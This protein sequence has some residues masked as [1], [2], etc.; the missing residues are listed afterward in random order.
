MNR[1]D[2]HFRAVNHGTNLPG[3]RIRIA[4]REEKCEIEGEKA[5]AF[6]FPWPGFVRTVWREDLVAEQHE[7]RGRTAEK[8]RSFIFKT[9]KRLS[10]ASR[11]FQT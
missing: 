1:F 10:D 4:L 7:E 3:S 5:E 2:I 6:S 11:A 9:A 8:R